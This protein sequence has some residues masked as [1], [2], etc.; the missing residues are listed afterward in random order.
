MKS[1]SGLAVEKEWRLRLL[2]LLFL[3]ATICGSLWPT[4]VSILSI[5]LHSSTFTH[6]FLIVPIVLY[7]V[8]KRRSQVF[9]L[10]PTSQWWA[11]FPL[12]GVL[13]IWL[14]SRVLDVNV[15]QHFAMV[16]LFPCAVWLTL[17][18]RVTWQLVFPLSYLF[19]AVPFGAF[20]V[21]HLQD[22]T[23]AFTVWMLNVTG[24]PVL[25]EGRFFTI[26]SGQFEVAAACSGIRYLIASIALGTL[27]AHLTYH[28]IY[29]RA[30]FIVL[31]IVV[32]ILANGL[33]AYLI[34]MIAHLSNYRLATGIDHL[35]YGWIFFGLIVTALFWVGLKFRD[36]EKSATVPQEVG[37]KTP[38]TWRSLALSGAIGASLIIATPCVE[39]ALVSGNNFIVELD[40]PVSSPPWSG[41]YS[42]VD[43]WMPEFLGA[44]S[45]TR[46]EYRNGIISIQVYAAYYARQAQGAE[47]VNSENRLFDPLHN[48]R[49]DERVVEIQTPDGSLFPVSETVLEARNVNRVI[50]H[51]FNVNSTTTANPIRA[52]I[53]EAL[54]LVTRSGRGSAIVAIAAQYKN[55]PDEARALLSEFLGSMGE[56]LDT[57]I[58]GAM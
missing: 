18:N 29:R 40:L 10:V 13:L 24:I 39:S 16:S 53:L 38:G 11:L 31:S 44:S 37:P 3:F 57:S 34:V 58:Q 26:P 33:R 46:R 45:T 9:S 19:F 51:W 8:W 27:F 35:I 55:S 22:I 17:G 47:L 49:L 50:W 12:A 20:L 56:K 4:A 14:G 15:G 42:S 21:P 41:P 36:T 54:S 28:S 2:V 25:W 23:A 1:S 30:A 43:E 7:L 48:R 32:P 5:W 6:G 52:K